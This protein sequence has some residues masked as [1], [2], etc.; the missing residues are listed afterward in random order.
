MI[1]GS[2]GREIIGKV[3][4]QAMCL[5]S[6]VW[7]AQI[8][9]KQVDKGWWGSPKER[10]AEANTN[11]NHNDERKE[12]VKQVDFTKVDSQ[13]F[14]IILAIAHLKFR[15][16]PL[17]LSYQEL[18]NVAKLCDYYDCV[19]LV[20]LFLPQWL[21][22][23]ATESLKPGQE[24]WLFI[25]WVFGRKKVFEKLAMHLVQEIWISEDEDAAYYTSGGRLVEP[26]PPKIIDKCLLQPPESLS[27]CG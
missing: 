17:N 20:T 18:L 4:S 8:F 5:A 15:D 27:T 22:D 19:D 10:L 7:K 9:P 6:P 23:E 2:E 25:A 24:N 13:A 14:S 16:V 21:S 1:T 3:C 11:G 26:M 12:P